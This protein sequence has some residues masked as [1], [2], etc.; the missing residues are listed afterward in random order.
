MR[1]SSLLTGDRLNRTVGFLKAIQ[2]LSARANT[3]AII[4]YMQYSLIV[5]F[6]YTSVMVIPPSSIPLAPF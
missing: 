5:D 4:A 1:G 2:A 3:L 6:S